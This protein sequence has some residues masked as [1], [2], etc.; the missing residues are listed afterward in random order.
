MQAFVIVCTDAIVVDRKKRTVWL[1]RRAVLPMKGL[2]IIGGRRFAGEAALD[3]ITRCFKRETGLTVTPERF[4]FIMAT[5]YR[6]KDREQEPQNLGSHNL[7]YTFAVEL[8]AEERITAANSLEKKEYQPGFGLQEF[9]RER[10]V[11]E[12]VHPVILDLY[13]EI[14]AD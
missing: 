10:S 7:S 1:A 14:F 13:D 5:E 4:S 11:R 6:W 2:W 9:D 12:H 3:S 8:T